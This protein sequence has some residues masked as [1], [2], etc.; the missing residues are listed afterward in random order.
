MYDC[1]I[2]LILAS[3]IHHPRR[4]LNRE[5]TP[6]EDFVGCLFARASGVHRLSVLLVVSEPSRAGWPCGGHHL[7]R[8]AAALHIRLRITLR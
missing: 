8:L 7:I 6:F 3:A 1:L 4:C 2:L 5:L